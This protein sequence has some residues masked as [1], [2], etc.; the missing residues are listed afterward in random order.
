MRLEKFLKLNRDLEEK[1]RVLNQHFDGARVG[2]EPKKR[3]REVGA[4]NDPSLV[5]KQ[6]VLPSVDGR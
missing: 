2:L 1:V 3:D 4:R 5:V 6:P